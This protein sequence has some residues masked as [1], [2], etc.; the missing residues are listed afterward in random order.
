M[1]EV[2]NTLVAS[3]T[4]GFG[5]EPSEALPDSMASGL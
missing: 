3:L 2:G 5:N 1:A 4:L